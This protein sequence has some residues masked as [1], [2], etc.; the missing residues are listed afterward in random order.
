MGVMN[1]YQ[2]VHNVVKKILLHETC[3]QPSGLMMMFGDTVNIHV[4][5]L[6]ALLNVVIITKCHVAV[7]LY[8][9]MIIIQLVW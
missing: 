9:C 6:M 7:H 1:I 8:C 3:C 5:R 4:G 2:Q